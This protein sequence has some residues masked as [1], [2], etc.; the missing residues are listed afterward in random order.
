MNNKFLFLIILLAFTSLQ[1][2]IISFNKDSLNI[3]WIE[4]KYAQC[5]SFII[6]NNGEN[7]LTIDSILTLNRYGYWLNRDSLNSA[8]LYYI[9]FDKPPINLNILPSDSVVYFIS[10]PDLCPICKKYTDV[11]YFTDTLIFVSNSISGRYTILDV[12]GINYL[13]SISNQG[14]IPVK[15]ELFQNYPNPFNPTTI[16]KY[17]IPH[18]SADGVKSEISNVKLVV[19]DVLGREIATLVNEKQ[20]PGNY[21]VEFDGSDLTS[22]IYFYKISSGSYTEVKKMILLK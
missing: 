15:F 5:D 14:K 19:Y 8:N 9:G 22:G 6:I 3:D 11:K 13:T 17:Q 21:E 1:A 2:Q 4:S 12:R 7:V 18:P 20:S 10:D 16:I